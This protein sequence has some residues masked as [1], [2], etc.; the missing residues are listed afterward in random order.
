MSDNLTRIK[1]III[2]TSKVDNNYSEVDINNYNQ[3]DNDDS[4]MELDISTLGN[5]ESSLNMDSN[6]NITESENLYKTLRK[7]KK[8]NYKKICVM[9][10]PN[11]KLG[12]AINDRL[13]RAAIK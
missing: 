12:I 7:I 9:K 1:E 11:K 2:D 3:L 5:N 8:L 13:K 6:Y 10:I 4:I